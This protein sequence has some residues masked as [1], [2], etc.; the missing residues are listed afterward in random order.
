MNRREKFVGLLFVCLAVL[1]GGC[2]A[3]AAPTPTATAEPTTTPAPS[4]TPSPTPLPPTPTPTPFQI[5]SPLEDVL[6]EELDDLEIFKNPLIT[7]VPGTDDG[8][9]GVDF[10]YYRWKGREVMLGLPVY[11]AISGKVVRILEDKFP[12]GNAVILETRLD[13]L[14]DEL[15]ARLAIPAP[16]DAPIPSTRLVCPAYPTISAESAERSL[17]TLYAHFDQLP[18]VN[19]GDEVACGQQIGVVGTTG[20]SSQ[21]HLHLEMRVGP[22]GYPITS[23][24]HYTTL[25][26]PEELAMYCFWRVSGVFQLVDPMRLLLP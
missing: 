26:T 21:P 9:H 10:A 11:A 18:L 24:Q 5:C 1:L 2:A 23:M 15:Q 8:H 4:S 16:L 22:A 20:Y 25:S 7:P 14:P 13:D 3:P 6:L 17:Y 19:P 12:Y